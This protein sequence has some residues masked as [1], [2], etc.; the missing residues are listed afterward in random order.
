MIVTPHS[1][2]FTRCKFLPLQFLLILLLYSPP[3]IS[4]LTKHRIC[5]HTYTQINNFFLNYLNT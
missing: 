3:S 5:L 2:Y 1:E 4:Q